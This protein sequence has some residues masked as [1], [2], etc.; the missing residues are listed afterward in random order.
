MTTNYEKAKQRFIA[1]HGEKQFQIRKFFWNNYLK[2][3]GNVPV[4]PRIESLKPF[5]PKTI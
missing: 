5:R 1:K 4:V 3:R 2:K